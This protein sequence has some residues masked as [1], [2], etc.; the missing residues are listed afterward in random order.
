VPGAIRYHGGNAADNALA[1]Y[2]ALRASGVEP[3]AAAGSLEGFDGLQRRCELVGTAGGVS[4]FDDLGKHPAALAA[5]IRALRDLSPR[6]LHLVYEPFLDLDV[7]RWRRRWVEA[8][9]LA[10][11]TIVLPVDSRTTGPVPRRAPPD[12]PRRAGSAADLAIDRPDAAD[13]VRRRC[14]P[15]DLVLVAGVH[16]D[17]GDYA[18]SV[19]AR[20]GGEHRSAAG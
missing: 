9:E 11:S 12:W 5:T 2:A 3:E 14:R 7:F 13:L 15:G 6:R 10:D 18:R 4:V 1:A 8:F 16:T 20:L 19:V 17:L